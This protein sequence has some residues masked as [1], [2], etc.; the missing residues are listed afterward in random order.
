MH[1]NSI[2]V[3][4]LS[5]NAFDDAPNTI[6]FT[7]TLMSH[8]YR[9]HYLHKFSIFECQANYI[10]GYNLSCS[11]LV[12]SFGPLLANACLKCRITVESWMLVLRPSFI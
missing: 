11:C 6:S 8:K 4:Y 9:F 2:S 3:E 7:H 12:F 5:N 1:K 10:T